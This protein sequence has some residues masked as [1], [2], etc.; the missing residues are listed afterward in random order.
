MDVKVTPWEMLDCLVSA[1]HRSHLHAPN[2]SLTRFADVA[3][4]TQGRMDNFEALLKFVASRASCAS[5]VSRNVEFVHVFLP[6]D[7]RIWWKD[8]L[9]HSALHCVRN[10]GC[11]PL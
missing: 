4:A 6:P 3:E 10:L 8:C 9:L 5:K 1:C 11:V 7:L 2:P